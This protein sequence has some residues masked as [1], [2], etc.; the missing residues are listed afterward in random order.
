MR[1]LQ[2]SGVVDEERDA[3]GDLLHRGGDPQDIG[4]D[5]FEGEFLVQERFVADG[6]EVD[7]AFITL[8]EMLDQF[9]GLA[10]GEGAGNLK[11]G[12]GPD[13]VNGGNHFVEFG[14]IREGLLVAVASNADGLHATG[15]DLIPQQMQVTGAVFVAVGQSMILAEEQGADFLSWERSKGQRGKEEG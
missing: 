14:A 4:V 3:G 10:G 11:D 15:L 2:P 8:G 5:L 12:F 13:G 6:P 1:F 9:G 7:V